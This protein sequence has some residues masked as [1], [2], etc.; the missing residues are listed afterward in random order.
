MPIIP[1]RAPPRAPL[2]AP[3][4]RLALSAG[5]P[6]QVLAYYRVHSQQISTTAREHQKACPAPREPARSRASRLPPCA[7]KGDAAR[8][9]EGE[10]LASSGDTLHRLRVAVDPALSRSAPELLRPKPAPRT[11]EAGARR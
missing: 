9:E 11:A 7:L 5:A 3:F 10:I 6:S 1:L 2:R 4:R 8:Q